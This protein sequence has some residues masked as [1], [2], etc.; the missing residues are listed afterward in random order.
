MCVAEGIADNIK[1]L[2]IIDVRAEDVQDLLWQSLGKAFVEF[3][4]SRQECALQ[5]LLL[6]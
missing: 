3:L 4:G 6:A 2:H 5:E 1:L